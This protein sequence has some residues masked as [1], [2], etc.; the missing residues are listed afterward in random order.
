MGASD[1]LP[2]A[3]RRSPL[4]RLILPVSSNSSSSTGPCDKSYRAVICRFCAV[5]WSI[6]SQSWSPLQMRIS[7]S[8]S[9]SIFLAVA[10]VSFGSNSSLP[11]GQGGK[12]RS[13]SV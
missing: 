1:F 9:M 12:I 8:P 6:A 13:F 11:A 3:P 4:A 5:F 10:A 2:S 7:F